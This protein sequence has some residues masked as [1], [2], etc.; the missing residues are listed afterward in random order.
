MQATARGVAEHRRQQRRRGEIGAR[1]RRHVVGD[2]DQ[3]CAADAAQGDRALAVLRRVEGVGRRDR[4]RR[5]RDGAEALRHD[6]EHPRAVEAAGDDQGRV[7]R[8]VVIAIER[9]Q[10]RDVDVLDVGAGADRRLAVVVPLVH[11]G[12]RLLQQHPGRA[13]LARFHLVA[14]DRH[15]GVEIGA[16]DEAVDHRVGLPAEVPAQ[17]VVVRRE[18]GEVVGAVV[19]GAAVGA[20]AALGELG[21][22]IAR[23]RRALEQQVLEQ[24]RHAGLAVA[25]E[26][27][28]DPVGDVDG[29]ARLGV[30][31]HEQQLQPVL[32]P[33]FGDAFDPGHLL[34]ARGQGRPGRVWAG[35]VVA[36]RV[37][38]KATSACLSMAG[39]DRDRKSR[40]VYGCG[41]C[42]AAGPAF[43]LAP[44][45]ACGLTP[46]PR[47]S[48]LTL[49]SSWLSPS[50]QRQAV[51]PR[52]RRPA[53]ALGARP[54]TC[55]RAPTCRARLRR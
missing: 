53:P 51:P 38:A 9:L 31:G 30:V 2:V 36:S 13:V 6:L 44:V 12:H 49:C 41:L 16:G 43:A 7:V 42:E 35:E 4:P 15:L 21:P 3:R 33:V 47:T 46:A 11:G 8:L 40:R 20:Q 48:K 25:L 26:A 5:P 37:K 39:T 27:R 19:P 10:P 17:V 52:P 29:G 34:D 23:R 14:H 54:A 1:C 18:G 22:D 32:Q 28:A 45:A 50:T 55:R 24:V